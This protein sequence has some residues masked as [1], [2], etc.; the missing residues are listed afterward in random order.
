MLFCSHY[1]AAQTVLFQALGGIG[2]NV[3]A[4]SEVITEILHGNSF[5]NKPDD[6]LKPTITFLKCTKRFK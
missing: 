4:Y 1:A 2:V 6:I 3:F 5:K